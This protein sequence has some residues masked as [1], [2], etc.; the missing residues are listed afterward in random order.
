MVDRQ[1]P[2]TN[3]PGP[4]LPNSTFLLLAGTCI[5]SVVFGSMHQALWLP[6]P[7]IAFVVYT[8]LEVGRGSAWAKREMDLTWRNVFDTWMS[9]LPFRGYGNFVF[10][11]PVINFVVFGFAWAVSSLF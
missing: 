2:K 11:N 7:P 1:G 6:V 10:L 3:A 9:G 4:L 5:G 8:L